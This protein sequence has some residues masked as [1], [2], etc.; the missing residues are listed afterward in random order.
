MR[1]TAAR[2]SDG[3]EIIYFDRDGTPPRMACDM[4]G[5]DAG[6][7]TQGELRHDALTGEWVA[8]A[9]HRQTRTFLPE[10]A[11]C[12]LCPTTSEHQSE[13]PE[14]DYDVVVFENRF[15]SFVMGDAHGLLGEQAPAHGRC[16][17]I[18][19]TPD[20]AG[21]M[22][23]LDQ[24]R[25]ALV[26]EAWVDRTAALEALPGVRSVFAFENRGAEIG[27]TLH[28]PHGQI[29]GYPFVP[30]A[31]ARVLAEAGKAHD[32]GDRLLADIVQREL[33]A[34]DRILH[35]DGDWV[36]FVPFAARWPYEVQ[37]HPVA[38]R[39]SLIELTAGER[40]SLAELY[41]RLVR[42]LDALFGAPLPFMAGWY[43]RPASP[44]PLEERDARLFLRIAS[45]RRDAGKLKYLA[46][47]E[48]LMGAFIGDVVPEQAAAA[49]REA[50][51]RT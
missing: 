36:A 51:A 42:G 3:R 22:A 35:C 39:A 6:S 7:T 45:N 9:G 23:T 10:A 37:V 18:S 17:V 27:V 26:V 13:I 12:P 25:M 16:E 15:P 34:G 46:G 49:I 20:H 24:T 44:T 5:L 21:S 43:Q 30:P 48:S 29:Y 11:S 4:R 1:R 50:M 47:S 32:R 19:Y 28:H 31:L 38:D 33:V 41:P 14:A 8:I 40:A 2:L